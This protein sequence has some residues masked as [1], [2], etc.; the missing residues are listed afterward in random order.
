M[1]TYNEGPPPPIKIFISFPKTNKL[2]MW[3]IKMHRIS[4]SEGA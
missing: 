3:D 1:Y 2:I 4:I